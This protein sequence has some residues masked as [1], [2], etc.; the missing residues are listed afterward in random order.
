MINKLKQIPLYTMIKSASIVSAIS[1]SIVLGFW[2]FK[3]FVVFNPF[4]SVLGLIFSPFLYWMG[5]V[6]KE[7]SINNENKNRQ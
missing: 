3:D 6:I 5:Q 2:L 7:K 1:Y 4:F